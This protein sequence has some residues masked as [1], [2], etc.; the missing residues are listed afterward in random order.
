[1][2]NCPSC[3]QEVTC[4][5]FSLSAFP[6]YFKCPSCNVRLK[7]L[8]SK[9]FWVITCLYLAVIIALITYIPIIREYNLGVIIAVLGWLIVY[10]KVSP[11]ILRKENLAIYE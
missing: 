9:L 6:L 5:S 1:M 2:N 7:L 10:S 3:N 8:N 4:F 11:Y